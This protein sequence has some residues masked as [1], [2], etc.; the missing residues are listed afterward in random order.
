[1]PEISRIVYLSLGH[2]FEING[3][4]TEVEL[5]HFRSLAPKYA[6]YSVG[7]YIHVNPV[8]SH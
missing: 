5:F 6:G 1:M 4:G 7:K 2:I 3:H 8:N